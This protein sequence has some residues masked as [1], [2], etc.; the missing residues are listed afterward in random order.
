MERIL[1]H[2]VDCRRKRHSH[3]R[4]TLTHATAAFIS[5]DTHTLTHTHMYVHLFTTTAAVQYNLAVRDIRRAQKLFSLPGSLSL[6]VGR[7]SVGWSIRSTKSASY[8][9]PSVCSTFS[10]LTTYLLTPHGEAI[11]RGG[12]GGI[13]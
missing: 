10:M 3:S 6:S 9:G 5:V 11:G 13:A 12:G 7:R 8:S 4:H 1:P 2:Q